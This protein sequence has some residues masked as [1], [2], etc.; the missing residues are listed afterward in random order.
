MFLLLLGLT[1]STGLNWDLPVDNCEIW[2]EEAHQIK[3]CNDEEICCYYTTN[4]CVGVWS[5][6]ER[7]SEKLDLAKIKWDLPLDCMVWDEE[8]NQIRCFNDD[9]ISCYYI[10]DYCVG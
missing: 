4:E 8:A 10:V 2:D 5:K 1:L 6:G 9:G 3:C 7:V